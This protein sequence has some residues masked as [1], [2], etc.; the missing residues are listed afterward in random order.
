MERLIH[1]RPIRNGYISPFSIG[2]EV[3]N[4]DGD[5]DGKG[6]ANQTRHVGLKCIYY[7][8]LELLVDGVQCILD[9]HSF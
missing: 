1:H 3:G 9:C 6:I 7:L 5:I 8:L 4:G 2:K